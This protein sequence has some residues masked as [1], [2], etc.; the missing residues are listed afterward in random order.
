MIVLTAGCLIS[1]NVKV[2]EAFHQRKQRYPLFGAYVSLP[3]Y[4]L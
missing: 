4:E 3:S 1:F 2:G